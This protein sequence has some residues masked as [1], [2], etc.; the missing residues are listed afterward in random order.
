MQGVPL[1]TL[2]PLLTQVHRIVPPATMLSELG[3]NRKPSLTLTSWMTLVA[4]GTPFI[5]RLGFLSTMLSG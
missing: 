2:W 1:V 5:E 3:T 4:N